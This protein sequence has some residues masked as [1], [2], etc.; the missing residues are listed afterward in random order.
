MKSISHNQLEALALGAGILGSGG[1]GDPFQQLIMTQFILETHGPVTLCDLADIQDN[2]FIVPVALMG[3]PS[4]F[5]EKIISK[6]QLTSL[7][8]HIEK[9][10]GKKPTMLVPAEIGGGNG[11]VPLAFAAATGLPLLNGDTLGRAFP[12]LQ[13]STCNLVGISASP[14]LLTGTCGDAAVVYADNAHGIE[15]MTRQATIAMGSVAAVAVYLMSGKQARTAVIPNTITQA[16]ELGTVILKARAAG[17]APL[18]ALTTYNDV[19]I[20]GSGIITDV[21]HQVHDGFLRG[22]YKIETESE[23]FVIA[24]QNENLVVYQNNQPVVTTPDIIIAVQAETGTPITCDSLAYGMRVALLTLPAP[25]A[26][27]TPAGLALTG[28]RSFGYNFDFYPFKRR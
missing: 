23:T 2:D 8:H 16:Y 13:I 18:K 17:Q 26:W 24:F 3:A 21:H 4:I 27:T 11:L 25:T 28:P 5:L 14:A 9:V 10:I 7:M 19:S 15:R 20:I 12:E 6:N 1:G 22:T